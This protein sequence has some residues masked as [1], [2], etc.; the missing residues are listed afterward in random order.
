MNKYSV[1]IDLGTTTIELC[2]ICNNEKNVVASD[3]FKNRQ[4]HT[5]TKLIYKIANI[6]VKEKDENR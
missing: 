6:G 2:I 1:A 4:K 3:S 5:L